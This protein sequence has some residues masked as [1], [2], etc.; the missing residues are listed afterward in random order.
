MASLLKI[1][2]LLIVSL[3][4]SSKLAYADYT[5]APTSVTIDTA[6]AYTNITENVSGGMTDLL[7]IG[8]YNIIYGV[9]PLTLTSIDKVFVAQLLAADGVTVLATIAPVPFA[10]HGYNQGTFGFYLTSAQ[11]IA[12]GITFNSPLSVRL[13]GNPSAWSNPSSVNTTLLTTWRSNNAQQGYWVSQD[14]LNQAALLA[15]NWS[16]ALLTNG[17]ILNATGTTYFSLAIPMIQQ[18]AI[19]IFPS[20]L[21]SGNFTPTTFTKSNETSVGNLLTAVGIKPAVSQLSGLLCG[22]TAGVSRCG[23]IA[24]DLLLLAGTILV[25]GYFITVTDK[26]WIGYLVATVMFTIIA[27]TGLVGFIF[28]T[29]AAV[30]SVTIIYFMIWGKKA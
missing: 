23:D 19:Q 25:A 14:V 11:V 29:I 4:F 7:V 27:F 22:F 15:S 1:L 20:A 21:T 18:A 9:D 8:N 6:Y 10:F 28:A 13:T 17:S 30:I 2:S 16:T 24:A 5:P 3:L 12:N 26:Q